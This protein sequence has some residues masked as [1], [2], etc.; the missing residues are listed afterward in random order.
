MSLAYGMKRKYCTWLGL[1][2]GLNACTP[3]PESGPHTSRL[4]GVWEAQSCYSVETNGA[5]RR[6]FA[7]TDR[8]LIGQLVCEITPTEVR[9]YQDGRA[10]VR[11]RYTHMPGGFRLV[12]GRGMGAIQ[13]PGDSV[14][15]VIEELTAT[16]LVL[17]QALP[18]SDT[19]TLTTTI[20]YAR[21]AIP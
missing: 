13:V 6:V 12:Q 18:S 11:A 17:Q 3:A 8:Y 14:E 19:T 10:Q 16:R 15:V 4:E 1:L 20:T 7:R 21:K 5:G 9:H 2:A